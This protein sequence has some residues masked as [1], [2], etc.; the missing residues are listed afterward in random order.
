MTRAAAAFRAPAILRPPDGSSAR[1]ALYSKRRVMARVDFE[2]VDQAGGRTRPAVIVVHGEWPGPP[3]GA[4]PP[5]ARGGS[6]ECG[7][8]ETTI[9]AFAV[10]AADAS[11]PA[12]HPGC[13]V[14][15][16]PV[17]PGE[18]AA[19]RQGFASQGVWPARTFG[20]IYRPDD[21]RTYCHV[22]RRSANAVCACV[23]GPTWVFVEDHHLALVPQ[24]VRQACA[25][26]VFLIVRWPVRWPDDGA[27]DRRPWGLAILEGLLGADL[28]LMATARDRR[29]F[30]E[31]AR[32]YCGAS[33]DERRGVLVHD[34]RRVL[35]V[36]DRIEPEWA[37]SRDVAPEADETCQ[38]P[39]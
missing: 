21:Y 26:G 16:V 19:Y 22:N 15:R 14:R 24:M 5:A 32:D 3:A 1:D 17:S 38:I 33:A 2:G 23:R 29:N 39:S 6:G 8:G 10:D 35:V 27:I 36:T 12:S 20:A 18:L 9:V 34:G 25:H 31:S 7:I 13:V 11:D 28:V 30:L 4:W 37:S